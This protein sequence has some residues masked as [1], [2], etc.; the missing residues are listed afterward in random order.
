MDEIVKRIHEEL[1]GK[2]HKMSFLASMEPASPDAEETSSEILISILSDQ[3]VEH[4]WGFLRLEMND[5]ILQKYNQRALQGIAHLYN[6]ETDDQI[7]I[8]TDPII[9]NGKLYFKTKYSQSAFAQE[10]KLDI[11]SGILPWTSGGFIINEI[12]LEKEEKV[13]D[14]TL[15]YY[16]CTNWTIVEGSSVTIPRDISV[17]FNRSFAQKPEE[18]PNNVVLNKGKENIMTPEEIAAEAAKKAAEGTTTIQLGEDK[19]RIELRRQSDI[20]SLAKDFQELVSPVEAREFIDGKKSAQEFNQL[21]LQRMTDR[22]NPESIPATSLGIPE[23]D[24]KKYALVPALDRLIAANG[25]VSRLSGIEGE[26]HRALEKIYSDQGM[27]SHGGLLVPYE[28]QHRKLITRSGTAGTPSAGGYLVGTQQMASSFVDLL[29]NDNALDKLGI[30]SLFGL[31][32]NL[33][34]PKQT[35]DATAYWVGEDVDVTESALTFG[36]YVMGPK[37]VGGHVLFSRKLLQNSDPS[38]EALVFKSL[39]R[40]LNIALDKAGIQGLGSAAQPQGVVGTDGVGAPTVSS[41]TWLKVLKI[42][43]LQGEANAMNFNN[44]KWL[45][46]YAVKEVLQSRLKDTYGAQYLMMENGNMAGFESIASNQAPA[47][48]LIFGA[49][50]ALI[51]G[52]WG[53]LELLP[54]PYSNSQKG[55]WKITGFVT[56]DY[57]VSQPTAF[58]VGESFS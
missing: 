47:S 34:V 2:E 28:V 14:M 1:I 51:R 15:Y 8:L 21:I 7:G 41:M 42:L 20:M 13:G 22:Y 30:T 17:G 24:L 3:Y 25:D 33:E 52:F 49:W 45:L 38:I 31:K 29:T 26:A 53:G 9:K 48:T 5:E 10:K 12:V 40:V 56:V 32:G 6:H 16:K 50:E 27:A 54:D 11:E 39:A 44:L 18:K 37:T 35:G 4:W 23:K 58:Q 43:T 36:Q 55:Q 57:A 46:P 19:D